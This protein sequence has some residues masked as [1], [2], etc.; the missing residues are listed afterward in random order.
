M[1]MQGRITRS[2]ERTCEACPEAVEGRGNLPSLEA[3][4]GPIFEGSRPSWLI[5]RRPRI[6]ILGDGPSHV[7]LREQSLARSKTGRSSQKT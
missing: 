3:V 7:W 1:K 2:I 4:L 5:Y 6:L